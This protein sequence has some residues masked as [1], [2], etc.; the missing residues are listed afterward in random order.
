MRPRSI[1]S[2]AVSEGDDRLVLAS[3]GGRDYLGDGVRRDR[4]E[5]ARWTSLAADQGEPR[6][7]FNLGLLCV[8]G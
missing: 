1:G 2:C 6:A 7:Q 8:A 3:L 5:V 4:L